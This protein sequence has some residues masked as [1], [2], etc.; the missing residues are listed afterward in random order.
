MTVCSIPRGLQVP[1]LKTKRAKG[2]SASARYF[3]TDQLPTGGKKKNGQ[4]KTA[5]VE[6]FEHD[7]IYACLN[8]L[9][10]KCGYSGRMYRSKDG[11]LLA[12]RR[13]ATRVNIK[14]KETAIS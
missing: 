12:S 7:S 4:P 11:E 2:N 1:R 14:E 8:Y 10:G 9:R 3:V 5:E 13:V 6:V